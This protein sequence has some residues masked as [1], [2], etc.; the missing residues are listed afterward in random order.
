MGAADAAGKAAGPGEPGGGGGGAARGLRRG[1]GAT[2][3]RGEFEAGSKGLNER[4]F[5]MQTK[6]IVCLAMENLSMG[7]RVH[8]LKSSVVF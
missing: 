5:D 2:V 1:T 4:P 6:S 3:F 8:Q 7:S